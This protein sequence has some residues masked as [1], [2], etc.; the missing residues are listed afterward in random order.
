M[1]CDTRLGVATQF[2]LTPII[3]K[4]VMT[5]LD[6]SLSLHPLLNIVCIRFGTYGMCK[7]TYRRCIYTV[8][9]W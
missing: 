4:Y 1:W 2:E 5:V 8:D 7:Y 3:T 9:L 6:A